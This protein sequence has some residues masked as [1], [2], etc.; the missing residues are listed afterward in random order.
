M[1][2]MKILA[3]LVCGAS[4]M[5]AQ[6]S[7]DTLVDRY[8]DDYFRLNPTAATAA[9]FHHPYDSQLEDFSARA[10]DQRIAMDEKYLAEFE[11]LPA[12]DDRDLMT[13]HL[14]GDLL[15]IRNTRQ[16]EIN[17]DF[18]SSGITGSIFTLMSRKFAPPEERLRDVIAREQ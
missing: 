18:Y 12:S 16:W 5:A 13:S 8:F 2:M 17:P 10:V 1:R 6:S 4:V 11:R 15:N 7:F 9:G 3:L 14:K